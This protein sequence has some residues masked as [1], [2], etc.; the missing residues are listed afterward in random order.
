MTG[1]EVHLAIDGT[2][3]GAFAVEGTLRPDAGRMLGTLAR[4]TELA[5]LSGDNAREQERFAGLLGDR[6]Q[7]RFSQ[8]PVDKLEFISQR[9]AAGRKVMMVGDG[10]NDAGALRQSDVGL[11]VIEETGAFSPAS[12]G[13]ISSDQVVKLDRIT[14]FARSAMRVIKAGFAISAAYNVVGIGVA[15]SGLLSPVFCAILMPISSITVVVFSTSAVAW[16]GRRQS[17]ADRRSDKRGRPSVNPLT[18]AVV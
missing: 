7:L 5:L 9:Q 2:Y 6:A 4:D 10:L 12:D 3:R 11:A 17:L 18:E 15:A 1:S 14:G 8:S 16:C 13:I